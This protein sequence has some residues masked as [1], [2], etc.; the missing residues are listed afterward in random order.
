MHP[1]SDMGEG[2]ELDLE[3]TLAVGGNGKVHAALKRL[4]RQGARRGGPHEARQVDYEDEVERQVQAWYAQ[5]H[6]EMKYV[7]FTKDLI[8]RAGVEPAGIDGLTEREL[9]E[10]INGQ[11]DAVKLG[12]TRLARDGYA[13]PE[14]VVKIVPYL[15]TV[16]R[17][18]GKRN[19]ERNTPS[20]GMAVAD[21]NSP[22]YEG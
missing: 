3:E 16:I 4:E 7:M 14:G 18:V 20:N 9:P 15:E 6:G 19:A 8:K 5:K 2:K 17:I 22:G 13:S 11:M 21:N 12:V 1:V 10:W